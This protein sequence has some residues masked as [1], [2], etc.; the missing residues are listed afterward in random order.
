MS[1]SDF[2]KQAAVRRNAVGIL[3]AGN[4]KKEA[5]FGAA[6]A[7]LSNSVKALLK[8][9]RE[10]V[11]YAK[12]TQRPVKNLIGWLKKDIG[13]YGPGVVKDANPINAVKNTV[14]DIQKAKD[15]IDWKLFDKT[16]KRIQFSNLKNYPGEAY[17]ANYISDILDAWREGKASLP[18][19]HAALN[20]DID[21]KASDIYRRYARFAKSKLDKA[22]NTA[23]SVAAG[24]GLS[25]AGL[26]AGI[27]IGK[28][29]N[30]KQA[31]LDKSAFDKRAGVL[32]ALLPILGGS[33]AAGA[34][35]GFAA[36][37]ATNKKTAAAA[38]GA[39]PA[40][41][42]AL[43][44][45]PA[46]A[47]VAKSQQQATTAQNQQQQAQ[48]QSGEQTPQA[49]TNTIADLTASLNKITDVAKNSIKPSEQNTVAQG[50]E[51]AQAEAVSG[52][53]KAA[54]LNKVAMEKRANVLR[55]IFVILQNK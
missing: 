46:P 26:G 29:T 10:S 47:T 16:K 45:A 9:M 36:G 5:A 44:P 19:W 20:P 37:K 14:A 27:G 3:V 50:G 23:T 7:Q 43:S 49:D 34:G 8:A 48:N 11:R 24:T 51:T 21:R 18:R 39:I 12:D 54:S 35:L 38:F 33:A 52:A 30:D 6:G 25:L 40:I 13:K 41:G 32:R 1:Y 2:K 4:M 53:L 55:A 42:N 31:S 15:I 28:A 17:S 22:K